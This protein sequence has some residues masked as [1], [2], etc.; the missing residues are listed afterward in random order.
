MAATLRLT[1]LCAALS[2]CNAPQTYALACSTL[3]PSWRTAE[4]DWH[5][6]IINTVQLDETEILRWNGVKI[7]E[8]RL[9]QYLERA[10]GFEPKPSVVLKID[11]ETNCAAVERIRDRIEAQMHCK[12]SRLCGEGEGSWGDGA[13]F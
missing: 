9:S 8:T 13:M 2:A 11:P 7:D 4:Q 5:H 10:Q 3:R 12:S 6:P 1:L